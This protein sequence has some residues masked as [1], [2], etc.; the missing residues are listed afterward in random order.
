M[1]QYLDQ[2]LT[3]PVP[4]LVYAPLPATGMEKVV[5][6]RTVPFAVVFVAVLPATPLIL[7]G[8]PVTRA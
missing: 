7:T 2:R 3:L 4:P 1:H 8:W 5:G 6:L